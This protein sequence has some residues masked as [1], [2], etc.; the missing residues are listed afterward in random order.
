MCEHPCWVSTVAQSPAVM[1]T[2]RASQHSNQTIQSPPTCESDSSFCSQRFP[3]GVSWHPV[4]YRGS[5]PPLGPVP[6]LAPCA[7][8]RYSHQTSRQVSDSFGYKN[9]PSL[10]MERRAQAKEGRGHTPAQH[11]AP[12]NPARGTKGRRRWLTFRRSPLFGL[13]RR[14]GAHD[15]PH[16]SEDLCATWD[17]LPGPSPP[18]QRNQCGSSTLNW[19][20]KKKKKKAPGSSPAAWYSASVGLGR[21]EPFLSF[22]SPTHALTHRASGSPRAFGTGPGRFARHR[23]RTLPRS[24][25][26]AGHG[27]ARPPAEAPEPAARAVREAL[28]RPC[29][30]TLRSPPGAR[31]GSRGAG[32]QS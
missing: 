12:P 24:L 20:R 28:A 17:P 23:P 26:G 13:Q 32:Y 11:G 30:R 8:S 14:E 25:L 16:G 9:L 15:G 1:G 19:R 29:C 5:P 2:G 18:L 4:P 6:T 31:A 27:A 7:C 22:F 10:V 3:G 21:W